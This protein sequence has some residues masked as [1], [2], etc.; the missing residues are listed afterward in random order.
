[1]SLIS[2]S[3]NEALI[4]LRISFSKSVVL[5]PLWNCILLRKARFAKLP[6]KWYVWYSSQS[7]SAS[8]ATINGLSGACFG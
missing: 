4:A 2:T 7:S 1:M 3:V 6:S 8:R 5:R